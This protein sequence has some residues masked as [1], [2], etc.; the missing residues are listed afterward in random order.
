MR[1]SAISLDRRVGQGRVE[2]A[3]QEAH[4]VVEQVEALEAVAHEVEVGLEARRRPS[5]AASARDPGSGDARNAIG[6]PHPAVGELVGVE[7]GA[8]EDG[9]AAA[10]G[11]AL[12]EVAGARAS[13][14]TASR[15]RSR[16][17]SRARPIAVYGQERRRGAGVRARR[18][19]RGCAASRRYAI[20]VVADRVAQLDR[21]PSGRPLG[22]AGG[23]VREAHLVLEV[24]LVEQRGLHDVAGTGPSARSSLLGALEE[25]VVLEDHRPEAD[26]LG[27]LEQ[28][29]AALGALEAVERGGELGLAREPLLLDD[30]REAEVDREHDDAGAAGRARR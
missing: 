29:A 3:L 4:P 13:A 17:S 23:Q 2:R 28:L 24:V 21:R 11:A 25:D 26:L 22:D 16:W 12:D 15:Q 5:A 6:D 1:R 30:D 14:R 18:A 19:E 7:V 27:D 10:A 9:A 20:L 8:Q